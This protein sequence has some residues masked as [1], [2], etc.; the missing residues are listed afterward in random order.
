MKV[1]YLSYSLV[2]SRKANSIQVMQMCQA[3]S[4]HAKNVR[5]FCRWGDR[6][7]GDVFDY[8]GITR[9]F[10]LHRLWTPETRMINRL[11]YAAA[12]NVAMRTLDAPDIV[13]TR[14]E[15]AAGMLGA[16]NRTRYPIVYEVHAPPARPF[17]RWWIGRLID[18]PNFLHLVA[19]SQALADE[20]LR[21]Y[22]NLSPE[23]VSVAHDGANDIAPSAS[24]APDPLAT[25]RPA[26]GRI[27]VGYVG[28]LRPGKGMEI[29]AQLAPL[30]PE[31]DFSVVGGDDAAIATWKRAIDY[32][33]LKLL[34]FV[35]PAEADAHIGRFDILLAPY[36]PEVMVGNGDLNI[37]PWMSPLKVFEYMR[38]AKPVVASDLPVLR[39]VL[40]DGVNAL[41]ANP[42][43]PADWAAKIARLAHDDGL[44]A[45]LGARAQ[46]D[47]R[48]HYTW[49]RRAEQILERVAVA[50]RSAAL[51]AATKPTPKLSRD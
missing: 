17:W 7:T 45:T 48:A 6:G 25:P 11:W 19:I 35:P 15:F 13:Y 44:R 16:F 37:S 27:Q 3:F 47:F 14:D 23:Q 46:Q 2:P 29:I 10:P 24:A 38:R 34:G 30:L 43:K 20:Y 40:K 36:Q 18:G 4:R 32:P 51:R 21:L 22:P 12:A 26:T 1:L 50:R 9:R 42:T 33:N 39:E 49:D 28:S 31:C 8:Y 41:L 5:L